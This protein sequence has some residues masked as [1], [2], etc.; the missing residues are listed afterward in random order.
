MPTR[1]RP[2]KSTAMANLQL[3][4][5]PSANH[6]WR[7]WNGRM[8]IGGPGRRYRRRVRELVAMAGLVGRFT[9]ERLKLSAVACPPD[10]RRRDLDNL[11]KA[12]LDALTHAGLW[13]DD[14][15]LDGDS[16]DRGPV[17]D[18]GQGCVLIQVEEV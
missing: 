8:V 13:K 6:Y 11:R 18:T 17:D 5:P 2:L 10:N 16:M 9:T 7:N 15:Q 3:P 1:S 14:S 12:M 4:W